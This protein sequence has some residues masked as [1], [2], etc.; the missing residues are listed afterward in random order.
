VTS[1]LVLDVDPGVAVGD[2][3]VEVRVADWPVLALLLAFKLVELSFEGGTGGRLRIGVEVLVES[4]TI[5]FPWTTILSLDFFKSR[6]RVTSP[7]KSRSK[8]VETLMLMTPRN[9]WSLRLN[10]F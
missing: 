5:S 10:F 9:P 2:G 4:W 1:L 7:P 3:E 8:A 6:V